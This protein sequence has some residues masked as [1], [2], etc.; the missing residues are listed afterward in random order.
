[1][2][3]RPITA[4][5]TSGY[6]FAD[7][8]GGFYPPGT[9]KRDM[10]AFYCR[11]FPVAELNF[12]YYRMPTARTLQALATKSPGGFAFWVKANQETTHKGNRAAAAPLLE[13]LSGMID[14]G[15][16]AGVLLQFPQSFHRT[17]VNRTYLAQTIDDLSS[18]PLAV[19]FRHASW[20]HDATFQGL[21]QR[22]VTLVIPDVP[23]IAALFHCEPILTSSTG[24]LR[25]HSRNADKWYAGAVERYDYHYSEEQLSELARI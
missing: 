22:G 10:F 4:V 5:G 21:Q 18:V 12:T 15:K 9:A 14:A 20:R 11:R 16:L 6:S 8:V 24:Y 13:A 2:T 7:W 3:G 19:E 23:S 1:M 25:M 17:P